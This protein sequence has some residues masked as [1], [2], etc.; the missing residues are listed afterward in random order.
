MITAKPTTEPTAIPALA[1]APSG[2]LMETAA[3]GDEGVAGV[4]S[5]A[6]VVLTV[7]DPGR[8]LIEIVTVGDE[9]VAGVTGGAGVVLIVADPGKPLKT[10]QRADSLAWTATMSLDGHAA[11]RQGDTRVAMTV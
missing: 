2:P 10:S 7:A 8:L 9:D 4:T 5:A 6:V 11:V 1:P 3:L